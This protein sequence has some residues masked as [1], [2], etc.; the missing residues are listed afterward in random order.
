MNLFSLSG[1]LIGL[2]CSILIILLLK[3]GETKLHKVWAFFNLTV[4]IWGLG[5][6]FIGL[7]SNRDLALLSWKF[8]HIGV[9]FIPITFYHVTCIFS[10]IKQKTFLFTIYILGFI[11][12][13]IGIFTNIFISKLEFLFNSFYYTKSEGII[14]PIFFIFWVGLVALGHIQL[15]KYYKS[16]SHIKKSQTL[17]FFYGVFTGFAGG[18][19]NFFPIL[20]WNI[21]PYSNFAIPIYC[22]IVTYAIIRYRLMDISIIITRTGIFVTIYSLVLGIPFV[23]AYTMRPYLIGLFGSNWWIAPLV[24]STFLATAGPFVYLYI[25]R[26]AEDRLLREQR[27]YQSTLRQASIGMTRI[28]DLQK[29]LNLIVHIVTRSV[30]LKHGSIYLLNEKTNQYFLRA[31]RDKGNLK[32]GFSLDSNSSLI[33]NLILQKEPLVYE[34]VKQKMQDYK[35]EK[36]ASLEK[37]MRSI[38]AAVVVPSFVEEKLLGFI[39][40]GEKISG[41]TYSQDD[42]NVLRIVG[43][44]FALAIENALSFEKMQNIQRQLSQSERLAAIGRFAANISHEIKNPLTAIKT[45]TEFLPNKFQDKEFIEKYSHIVL[46]EVD[47][48]NN[49]SHELLDFSKPSSL[50]LEEIDIHKLLSET[51]DLLGNDFIKH[52]IKVIADYTDKNLITQIDAN[53]IKQAFLN[54]FLNAIEAMPSGGTLKV[55]T[56]L[57]SSVASQSVLICVQDSGIG[58][59][60]ESLS[61]IF[62]PFYSTKEKGTGLG[63]AI[64]YS[65][66]EEHKGNILI[67]SEV[68]KGTK[69]IIELP[70]S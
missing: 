27:R 18:I 70:L 69:F 20:G 48:I 21:Y 12:L 51:L 5:C 24:L 42:L 14:Y 33:W 44:Q 26:R 2:T 61:H 15:L 43:N 8:A 23:V 22:I 25:Q 47:K 16:A 52:K 53:R 32:P 17:Y 67:E 7:A 62:E 55:S 13:Y 54:L 49:L 1:L 30:R 6:F 57:C 28:R 63:L 66:I 34:E 45:F 68:G 46:E 36:L 65:I 59:P 38:D 3:Y 60:E 64:T 31:I 50:K 58:I 19:M 40:L 56:N 39:V 29:L 41:K 37:E 4:G 9:I 35:D 10:E 11:F